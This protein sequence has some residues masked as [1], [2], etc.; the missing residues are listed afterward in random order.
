MSS[1]PNS[2]L[3]PHPADDALRAA[4]RASVQAPEADTT[5]LLAMQDRILAQWATRQAAQATN[6]AP[7]LIKTGGSSGSGALAG[8]QDGSPHKQRQWQLS[9]GFAAL[10]LLLVVAFQA[11]QTG[12]DTNM[13]DLLEPDVLA[14]IAM[15][16][17]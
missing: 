15:G 11:T 9:A 16:E 8:L 6:T 1:V 7:G 5:A 17:L 2:H 13:D 3:D 14:L 12:R 4:L 10:A